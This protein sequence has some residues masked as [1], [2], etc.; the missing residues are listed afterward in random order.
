MKQRKNKYDLYVKP[1]L[2][3]VEQWARFLTNGDLAK[4]LGIGVTTFD[5]YKRQYPEF[6]CA[7]VRGRQGLVSDLKSALVKRAVGFIYEE[8][9]ETYD[10]DGVL[11]NKKI[12]EKKALP[13]IN[14]ITSLLRN[15]DPDWINKDKDDIEFKKRELELKERALELKGGGDEIVG[16]V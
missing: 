6:E 8:K 14:A 13:D 3:Q 2:E 9:T 16:E 5:K 1:K 15:Y 4:M 12:A 10:A 11:I 7:I